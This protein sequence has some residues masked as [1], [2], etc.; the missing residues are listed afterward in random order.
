MRM[1]ANRTS[2]HFIAE[3]FNMKMLSKLTMSCNQLCIFLTRA[4]YCAILIVHPPTP[5]RRAA[6]TQHKF[7]LCEM[8]KKEQAP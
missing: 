5:K 2:A 7:V 6:S 3:D 8:P 1:F 4:K